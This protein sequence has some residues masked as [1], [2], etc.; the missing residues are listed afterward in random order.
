[1]NQQEGMEFVKRKEKLDLRKYSG[2]SKV[3]KVKARVEVEKLETDQEKELFDLIKAERM[4]IAK[5]ER[6]PPFMI[7]HDKTLVDM[8]KKKIVRLADVSSI[9]GVGSVKADKYAFPFIKIISDYL[10]YE[11][12]SAR[13][14]EERRRREEYN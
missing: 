9:S 8:V 5:S 4:R 12:R 14:E 13:E 11:E 6:V 2:S 3:K 10:D 1:M 7:F